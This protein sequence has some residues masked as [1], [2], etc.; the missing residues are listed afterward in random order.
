MERILRK[1][2]HILTGWFLTLILW[3]SW[4]AKERRKICKGCEFRKYFVCG[5]CGC[6]IAAKS[7][8]KDEECP[9]KKW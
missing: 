5:E 2:G 4:W 3:D 7:R 9:A 1:I 6:V 8:I